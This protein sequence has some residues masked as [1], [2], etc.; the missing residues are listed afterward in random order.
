MW[1][2]NCSHLAL[3]LFPQNPPLE[4]FPRRTLTQDNPTDFQPQVHREGASHIELAWS[5]TPRFS[6][7]TFDSDTIC[8]VASEPYYNSMILYGLGR[9]RTSLFL[10][11]SLK[12][13][14]YRVNYWL[15]YIQE[16]YLL[17]SR[18][19]TWVN[20]TQQD[21]FI[22][23]YFFVEWLVPSSLSFCRYRHF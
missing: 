9:A 2:L 22:I 7:H 14:Y 5:I 8:W 17:F 15:L 12:A 16:N 21:L 19:D 1:H 6:F 11:T 23:F 20:T 10:G 3:L 4:N 18:C 13:S